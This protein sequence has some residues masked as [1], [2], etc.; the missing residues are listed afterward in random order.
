[1]GDFS[2][3]RSNRLNAIEPGRDFAELG[4]PGGA[5][6]W[7][8]P[9]PARARRRLSAS[10]SKLWSGRTASCIR[11]M[12]SCARRRFIL[13]RRSSTAAGN[14][15]LL[16][17]RSS[18]GETINGLYKAEL[19]WR[20][21]PWR[22]FEAVEFET[23]EWVDW[24]NNRRWVDRQH[25]AGPSRSALLRATGG[26]HDGGVPQTKWPPAIPRAVQGRRRRD[27]SLKV[28]RRFLNLKNPFAA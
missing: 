1:M 4:A 15:D 10:G 21:R 24:F 17:R 3:F 9:A 27:L 14:N 22:N 19:I 28:A 7:R 20:R 8:P 18:G 23:L 25:A 6:L 11:P 16:Q 13:R 26:A 5:R 2:N 12:R